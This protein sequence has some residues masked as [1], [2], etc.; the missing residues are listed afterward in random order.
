MS[1]V[2]PPPYKR[3]VFVCLNDR[4]PGHPK[5]SCAQKGSE[6]LLKQL[7]GACKAA[8][9]DEDGQRSVRRAGSALK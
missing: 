5:G 6:A 2:M 7:K 9:L 4:G 1:C 3:H 8:G